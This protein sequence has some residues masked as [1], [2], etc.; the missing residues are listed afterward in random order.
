MSGGQGTFVRPD[1]DAASSGDLLRL[2]EGW[3]LVVAGRDGI[4]RRGADD[5]LLLPRGAV[6]VKSLATEIHQPRA[7][8]RLRAVLEGG[9]PGRGA[10]LVDE[11]V[12]HGV[13]VPWSLGDRLAE[14]HARTTGWDADGGPSPAADTRLLLREYAG[15]QAVE[16]APAPAPAL[17]LGD[18]LRRRRSTRDFTAASID[19]DTISALLAW[20]LGTGDAAGLPHAAGG[21]PGH[22]T[23]PS[24][25]A[26]YAVEAHL[27]A[28]RVSDLGAGVWRYQPL[29][30]R[31][32]RRAAVPSPEQLTQLLA[33]C[34]TSGLAAVVVLSADW[35]RPSLARYGQKAYRLAT[36]EAGHM[37]QSVCL[38]ATGLGLGSLGLCGFADQPLAI[39][40]GLE[41]PHEVVLYAIA[42]GAPSE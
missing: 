35:S 22:R 34:E 6:L 40:C 12:E 18:A 38:V 7:E 15:G 37:G 14:L 42:L 25:G 41:P 3:E 24:G 11:L 9:F 8:R 23:Y 21:L 13:L 1:R 28:M 16:L 2:G 30:H 4:A 20:G 26:L 5:E 29:S 32:A 10:R 31:L 17:S 33:P 39:A 36:L 19:L 27:M